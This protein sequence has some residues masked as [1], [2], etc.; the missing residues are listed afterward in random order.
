M[1]GIF[2]ELENSSK[3]SQ[4]EFSMQQAISEFLV[5][6]GHPVDKAFVEDMAAQYTRDW[7]QHVR[8]PAGMTGY[9]T[10]LSKK[11]RLGLI[12]NTHYAPMVHELLAEMG[13]APLFEV[14]TTSIEHGRPK[15]H[16]E[17]FEDTL[18]AMQLSAEEAVYVG[19]NFDA[20]YRGATGVGMDCYL[21][22]RHAR[23]PLERQIPSV[24]ALPSRL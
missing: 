21:V 6:F 13:V 24:L 14:V 12:T 5:S 11:Y 3:Q 8:V 7:A 1:D 23:V 17:I 2:V 9:L 10:S 4:R 22:G 18:A 16:R 20:D 15:P 19:D